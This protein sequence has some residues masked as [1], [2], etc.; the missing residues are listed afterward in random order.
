[1]SS[2]EFQPGDK[3]LFN[4]RKGFARGT[5]QE[6]VTKETPMGNKTVHASKEEPQYIIHHDKTGELHNRHIEKV[7]PR[8]EKE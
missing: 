7:H 6:K 5:I 8:D 2:E 4:Y 3:V 1:M